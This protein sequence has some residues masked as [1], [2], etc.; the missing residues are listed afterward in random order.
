MELEFITKR[1]LIEVSDQAKASDRLRKNYNFH[2]A[3]DDPCHR[4]LNAVELNTYVPPHCHLDKD[5]TM[6]MVA[7][8]M[9]LL[10]FDDKGNVSQHVVLSAHGDCVGV[11]IPKGTFHSLVAL[12]SNTVFFES[13]AG[14]Y[15]ALLPE[16]KAAWAPEESDPSSQDFLTAWFALFL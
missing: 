5:E 10:F 14:P 8:E 7:G 3:N 12:K 9:G 1:L 2:E 15:R 6:V 13:K 11:N 4:L 16:E